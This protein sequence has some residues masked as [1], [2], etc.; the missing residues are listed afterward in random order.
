MKLSLLELTQNILSALD[1]DEVN[2]ISDTAEARQVAQVIRTAYFN[3]VSRANLT[4]HQQLFSLDSSGFVIMTKPEHVSRI[5][6]IKYNK[7]DGVDDNYVYVTILPLQ[8][9]LD[10]SHQLNSSDITVDSFSLNGETFYYKN[11]KQ[12]D[13]CTIVADNYIVFDS[14]DLSID[15]QLQTSKTLCF[16]LIIPIFLIEDSFIPDIDEQQFPLLLNEAKS[17]A[18]LELK[19][20]AHDQAVLESRRQW[21]SLQRNKELS[22]QKYFDQLPNFSRIPHVR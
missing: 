13:F 9:F 17:L 6:W 2:S 8:Q 10:M 16:G 20:I 15:S 19:Q 5:D 4:E 12:P 3:I 22:R 1:S 21:R 18:F 7:F 11:D 14:V